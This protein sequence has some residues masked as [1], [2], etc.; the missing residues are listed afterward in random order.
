MNIGR[1]VTLNVT[2]SKI[3]NL[4]NTL[5][6][7]KTSLKI[8]LLRL[9]PCS[10]TLRHGKGNVALERYAM[11]DL[12]ESLEFK[13]RA[14]NRACWKTPP[15]ADSSL[16]SRHNTPSDTTLH[17]NQPLKYM[18]TAQ[19]P[20]THSDRPDTKQLWGHY[21]LFQTLI[22]THPHRESHFPSTCW[23][24]KTFPVPNSKWCV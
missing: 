8:S 7:S 9:K 14:E 10:L 22:L 18:M 16:W 5:K 17:A 1:N 3:I 12:L 4:T 20:V 19:R 11:N 2:H 13:V 23:L 24:P 6:Q 15:R 21:F